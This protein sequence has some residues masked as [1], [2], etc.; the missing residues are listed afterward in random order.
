M[1]LKNKVESFLTKSIS[2]FYHLCRGN[3]KVAYVSYSS[4]KYRKKNPKSKNDKMRIVFIVQR[5]EVFNSVRSI[6]DAAVEDPRCEVFLLPIPRC[7]NRR[8]ELLWDTYPAIVDFCKELNAGTIIETYDFERKEYFDLNKINPDYIFLNVPYTEQYPEIYRIK[9][10]SHVSKVCFVPYGATTSN[11]KKYEFLAFGGYTPDFLGYLSYLFCDGESSYNYCKKKAFLSQIITGNNIYS[12][13]YPRFDM[14]WD[15]Y[16]HDNKTVLWLPRWTTK[17]QAEKWCNLGSTFFDYYTIFIDY[18]NKKIDKNLIVRPHPLA[19]ENYIQTGLMSEEDVKKYKKTISM[20]SNI[21]LD[22]K[23]SYE[24]AFN[25]ADILIADNTSLIIEYFLTGKPII[26]TGSR[27][28]FSTSISSVIDSF[29]YAK[30]WNQLS[31]I[32]EELFSGNDTLRTKR[33]EAVFNFR[34]FH[35]DAGKSIKKQL[36]DDWMCK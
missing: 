27:S 35:K 3:L 9:E 19:F 33:E 30:N 29:Y 18:F 31:K 10:L 7:A 23:S 4:N 32:L 11:E 8:F 15:S 28:D 25:R 1:G 17:E 34:S 36:L 13:G 26:Y 14:R 6:F 20:T 22:E 2:G 5:T 16:E 21:Y 24:A 12:L